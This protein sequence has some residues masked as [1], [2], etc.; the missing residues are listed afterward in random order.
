[1]PPIK[2]NI[3]PAEPEIEEEE[4]VEP[5]PLQISLTAR[6]T[7][8]GKIMVTNIMNLIIPHFFNHIF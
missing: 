1:M 8:D 5:K 4:A 6:K 2:I 3:A 7:L